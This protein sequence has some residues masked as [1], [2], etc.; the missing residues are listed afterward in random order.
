MQHGMTMQ[1]RT[2]SNT[3]ASLTFEKIIQEWNIHQRR[4]TMIK[5][6]QLARSLKIQI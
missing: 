3:D 1:E 2:E 6:I 4:S 5:P